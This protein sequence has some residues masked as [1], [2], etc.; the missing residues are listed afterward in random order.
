MAKQIAAF[1]ITHVPTGKYYVGFTSDLAKQVR[2]QVMLLRNKKH[3]APS[4]QQAFDS[5][6]QEDPLSWKIVITST[7][8]EAKALLEKWLVD[9]CDD[10]LLTNVKK[11]RLAQNKIGAYVV[12]HAPTGKFYIGSSEDTHGRYSHHMWAL[13]EGRHKNSALQE[14][15]TGDL[16]EF[17]RE[18]IYTKTRETAYQV[19]QDLITANLNNPLCLN[20]ANNARSSITS[21]ME[22]V[23]MKQLAKERRIEALKR[24]ETIAKRNA[25]LRKRWEDNSLRETRMGG[26]NPFAKKIMLDGK[27]WGSL[28]D[29]IRA[30]VYSRYRLENR[31]NDSTD[32]ACYYLS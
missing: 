14:L 8:D 15:Y 16:T 11:S 29:V 27:E 3:K 17:K 24:P 9:N 20:I 5:T 18:C 21:V 22:D 7:T 26:N 25:S 23:K 13:K 28:N 12:I 6:D 10:P 2:Y 31:L 19:E 4:F 1:R 30:G 32:T